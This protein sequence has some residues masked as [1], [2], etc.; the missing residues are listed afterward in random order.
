MSTTNMHLRRVPAD[1]W[2]RVRKTCQKRG[3][4]AREF[5][6]EAIRKAVREHR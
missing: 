3:I 5:V 6:I 4:S 1:L 2:L